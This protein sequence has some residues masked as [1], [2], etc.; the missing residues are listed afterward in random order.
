MSEPNQNHA[1]RISKLETAVGNIVAVMDRLEKGQSDMMQKIS[2]IGKPNWSNYIAAIAVI[3][4]MGLLVYGAAIHPLN[5]EIT[6]VKE[7]GKALA[8]AVIEQNK[9]IE[10]IEFTQAQVKSLQTVHEREINDIIEHGSANADKRIS[11]LEYRIDHSS[12]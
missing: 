1:E 11:I 7:S 5:T 4:S 2:D 9:R 10:S 3:L 8:T 6:D 12:H